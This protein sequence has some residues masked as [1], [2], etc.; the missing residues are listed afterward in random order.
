[1]LLQ[2][3]NRILTTSHVPQKWKQYQVVFYDKPEVCKVRPILLSSTVGKVFER[4]VNERDWCGGPKRITLSQRG[5][6]G[7]LWK[8]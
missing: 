2:I 4:V 7:K 3:F 6:V 8:I 1:M 5:K